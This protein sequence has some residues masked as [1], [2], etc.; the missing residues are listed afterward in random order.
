MGALKTIEPL[1]YLRLLALVQNSDMVLT[2]SGGLPREAVWSGKKCVV[3]YGSDLWPD[4]IENNWAK[5]AK[6]SRSSIEKAVQDAV[7][8]DASCTRQHFG[9]GK[10]AEKIVETIS[11]RMYDELTGSIISMK[12]SIGSAGLCKSAKHG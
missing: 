7:A 1:T 9:G 4:L 10:A 11:S 5:L 8:P 6:R 2:D 12:S 3:L